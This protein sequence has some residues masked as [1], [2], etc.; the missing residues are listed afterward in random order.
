MFFRK[1]YA[2]IFL[3]I[4]LFSF[5]LSFAQDNYD[6]PVPQ[7]ATEKKKEMPKS[8]LGIDSQNWVYEIPWGWQEIT[9]YYK[10]QNPVYGWKFLDQSGL[11]EKKD[12]F[13]AQNTLVFKKGDQ[14][15]IVGQFPSFQQGQDN[16][17]TTFF[18]NIFGKK[19]QNN[20]DQQE[21]LMKNIPQELPDLK[22]LPEGFDASEMFSNVLGKKKFKEYVKDVPIYP[23]AEEVATQKMK[24]MVN[25]M[26]RIKAS[27][28][29]IENFYLTN[30]P[31]QGW[32]LTKKEDPKSLEKVFAKFRDFSEDKCTTCESSPSSPQVAKALKS[33]NI[34]T[35]LNFE[36]N[37]NNCAITVMDVNP[38]YNVLS[39]SYRQGDNQE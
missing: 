14:T 2:I 32:V 29:L 5:S 13:F 10:A 15:L 25:G 9:D 11:S 7:V 24:N 27:A 8:I 20:I 33:L 26:F 30:M 35:I 28:Q 18:I 17:N 4:F 36:K 21:D 31:N 22:N 19:N 23:E 6:F 38:D 16:Q 1:K 3:F 34:K 37:K 12:S 39:I